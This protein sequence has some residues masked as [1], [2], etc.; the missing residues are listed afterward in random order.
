M[1]IFLS[2]FSDY[3]SV[4]FKMC[5]LCIVNEILFIAYMQLV[6]LQFYNEPDVTFLLVT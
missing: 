6:C 1:Y 3:D 4:F 2:F 5:A